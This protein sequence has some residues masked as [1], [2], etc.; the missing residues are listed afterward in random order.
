MERLGRLVAYL[1][2]TRKPFVFE[3]ESIEFTA[4]D[5]YMACMAKDD[6][7][8]VTVRFVEL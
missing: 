7:V 5:K 6:A 3:G 1:I 2:A 8:L 4:T